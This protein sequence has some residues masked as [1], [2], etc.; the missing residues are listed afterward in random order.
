MLVSIT[1]LWATI[2]TQDILNMN[3]AWE[4]HNHI[5]FQVLTAVS[6]KFRFVFWVVLPCKIIVDRRFR[7]TCCLHHQGDSSTI[8][9]H[10][11]TTQKKNLN[12]L[13]NHVWLREDVNCN[14][15]L[16]HTYCDEISLYW[17]GPVSMCDLCTT[18]MKDGKIRAYTFNR[19]IYRIIM[20]TQVLPSFFLFSQIHLRVLLM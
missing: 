8:I 7:G 6:M 4:L 13:L 16:L 9:L 19:Y 2:W 17:N 11:S 1:S 14:K 10:G 20:S 3:Q 18:A 12:F 15:Y 5:R